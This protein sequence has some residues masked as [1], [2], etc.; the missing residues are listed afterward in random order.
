MPLCTFLRNCPQISGDTFATL[1]KL[2]RGPQYFNAKIW[3]KPPHMFFRPEDESNAQIVQWLPP[4]IYNIMPLSFR[5]ICWKKQN[6]NSDSPYYQSCHRRKQMKASSNVSTYM[7]RRQN[8]HNIL[9]YNVAPRSLKWPETKTSVYFKHMQRT[10][11]NN[12][13]WI[14][15][16]VFQ[17]F[18]N[19]ANHI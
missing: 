15:L 2:G 17:L 9:C 8:R 10:F 7:L 14:S 12:N 13:I 1:Q 6:I 3:V 19:T 16:L 4:R 11:P 18:N 5:F